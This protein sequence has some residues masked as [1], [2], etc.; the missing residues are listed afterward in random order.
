M[1]ANGEIDMSQT[2]IYDLLAIVDMI[3][4]IPI[5]GEDPEDLLQEWKFVRDQV[6]GLLNGDII[7]RLSLWL[8]ELLESTWNG[9]QNI[10][11]YISYI[12][13]N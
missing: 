10:W 2:N 12:I 4:Q 7:P 9:I 5:N 8:Q 11:N 1:D 6:L 13:S 3:S